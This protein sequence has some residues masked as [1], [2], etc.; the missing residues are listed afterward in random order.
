MVSSI[1]FKFFDKIRNLIK[2]QKL[3]LLVFSL[4]GVFAQSGFTAFSNY[5]S[6]LVGEQA[7]GLAGAYTALYGDAAA[8]PFYNP[9]GLAWMEGNSFSAAVSIYKKFDS[10]VGK[11][12]NFL[13]APLRVNQ[14]FFQSIPASTGSVFRWQDYIVGMSIVVPDY[15][16]FKGDINTTKSNT[17]TLSF[18]DESLWV[19]G[20]ISRQISKRQTLGL[21][22]YYTAR[23]YTRTVQDRTVD[24][25]SNTADMFS[26]EKNILGN[27]VVAI[28]GYQIHWNR[29]FF[30][31][32]SF[33]SPALEVSGSGSYFQSR[34]SAITTGTANQV[35]LRISSTAKPTMSSHTRIPGKVSLGFAYKDGPITLVLDGSIY[36]SEKYF[37]LDDR[38]YRSKVQHQVMPNGAIGIEYQALPNLILRSGWFTNLTS[39]KELELEDKYGDRVDQ[40]GWAANFT[41]ISKEQVKFTFG[42]YY[43]GGRGKTIQR[44]DQQYQIVPKMSQVFTMLVGTSYA[45]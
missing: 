5:N 23:N 36:S 26:E 20:T 3:N 45:F 31:G 9:A 4:V 32:L 38:E 34:V 28:L 30:T 11:E 27:G 35:D 42:G 1:T 16:T 12:E 29:Y 8:G 41:F 15:D 7:A 6:I 14:G 19:G 25:V 24:D 22:I 44:I 18:L 43:V 37:D 13:S 39:Q 17:S 10:V 40:L 2:L 21:T 33:R